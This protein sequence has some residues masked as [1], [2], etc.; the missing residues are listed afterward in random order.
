MSARNSSYSP[1]TQ[2]HSMYS[3]FGAAVKEAA[4]KIIEAVLPDPAALEAELQ[5]KLHGLSLVRVAAENEFKRLASLFEC[6]ER[7]CAYAPA[8]YEGN[9]QRYDFQESKESRLQEIRDAGITARRAEWEYFAAMPP[10]Q[11][12]G[13]FDPNAYREERSGNGFFNRVL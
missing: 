13:N 9:K 3:D 10:R 4:S 12:P 1:T 2:P 6:D 11:R 8:T 7:N 5:E